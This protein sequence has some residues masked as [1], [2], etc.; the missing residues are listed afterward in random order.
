MGLNSQQE[1]NPP[2]SNNHFRTGTQNMSVKI[3][4]IYTNE[5]I[6]IL[7]ENSLFTT[8]LVYFQIDIITCKHYCSINRVNSRSLYDILAQWKIFQL[9]LS[10]GTGTRYYFEM[11]I[12]LKIKINVVPIVTHQRYIPPSAPILTAR[13]LSSF[14]HISLK[15]KH[16]STE[17]E[18]QISQNIIELSLYNPLLESTTELLFSFFNSQVKIS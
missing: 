14:I 10:L 2:R 16:S 5:Q 3:F 4:P 17:I 9:L 11:I 15:N 1:Q 6:G 13:A 12:D 8:R 18:M 7:W